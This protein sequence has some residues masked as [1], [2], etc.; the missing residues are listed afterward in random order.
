MGLVFWRRCKFSNENHHLEIHWNGC[1]ISIFVSILCF[2]SS[3]RYV[4]SYLICEYWRNFVRI[5][6]GGFGSD[7]EVFWELFCPSD[8]LNSMALPSCYVKLVFTMRHCIQNNSIPAHFIL[9]LH[10]IS[11]PFQKLLTKLKKFQHINARDTKA[12]T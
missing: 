10:Q 4:H 5:F 9:F 3:C 7:F 11:K 8:E 6:D 12:F 2:V 1:L